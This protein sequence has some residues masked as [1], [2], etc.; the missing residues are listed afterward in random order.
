MSFMP[1]NWTIDSKERL[2]ITIAEDDVTLEQ[3][4]EYIAA[5]KGAGA[6]SYRNLVDGSRGSTYMTS[7]DMLQIGVQVRSLHATTESLGPLAVVLPADQ[8][9][10]MSRMLGILAVADR[11]MRVFSDVEPA[12]RWIE[13][14]PKQATQR[15]AVG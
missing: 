3:V 5:V 4:E 15:A 2:V 9:E 14:L 11:P 6:L 10:L 1:L 12:R 13:S 8:F 7:E